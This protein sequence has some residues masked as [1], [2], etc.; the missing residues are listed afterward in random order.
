MSQGTDLVAGYRAVLGVDTARIGSTIDAVATRFVREWLIQKPELRDVMENWD[1]E[2]DLSITPSNNLKV[3]DDS[4]IRSGIIRKRISFTNINPS[5]TFRIDVYAHSIS[6]KHS[7][8]I[9]EGSC[10]AISQLQAVEKVATPNIVRNVLN[11]LDVVDGDTRLTGAPTRVNVGAVDD[12]LDAIFDENRLCTVFV[13]ASP[14][15]TED[16]NW[17]KVVEGM[18]RN[19]VG[20]SAVYVVLGMAVATLNDRL[21]THLQVRPGQVRSFA[22]DVQVEDPADG[23]RHRFIGPMAIS[24]AIN[25]TATGAL[26]VSNSIAVNQ[27]RLPRLRML[28]APVPSE[29]KRT[30]E[31]LDRIDLENKAKARA[32]SRLQA[33]KPR[34]STRPWV[35]SQE[36]RTFGG[37]LAPQIKSVLSA[38]SMLFQKWVG[39]DRLVQES[40]NDLDTFIS[41]QQTHAAIHEE[42]ATEHEK[43]LM[44]VK[45][46]LD[47]EK[48]LREH[49]EIELAQL[50]EEA[51]DLLRQQ[52]YF[53][54]LALSSTRLNEGWVEPDEH[55]EDGPSD[56]L[57]LVGRLSTSESEWAHVNEYV[58]FTGDTKSI[59][60][61]VRR[62]PL[63]RYASALWPVVRSL[64]D[65]AKLSLAGEVSC[66]FRDY[67]LDTKTDGFR[68]SAKRCVLTESESVRSNRAMK[69]ARTFPV[70]T[71]VDT[72]GVVFMEAHY[73][74]ETKDS[75]SP[76]MY[77]HHSTKTGKFYIGYIGKHLPNTKTN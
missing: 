74:I 25:S 33:F 21:P 9:V 22:R 3:I 50:Q 64:R 32:V 61:L 15:N 41:D 12:V 29:L 40:I 75:I 26:R 31:L 46:Q 27:A 62:D 10:D 24:Q 48:N 76:R 1:G 34:A 4:D 67:L 68:V 69:K 45:S 39:T 16:D 49:F 52:E 13:A 73:K 17:A 11:E 53:R 77:F 8:L 71:D 19:A 18:T 60:E 36:G 14:G 2:H 54:R 6:G 55:W 57:E 20:V 58:V 56:L 65:Y 47:A 38:L 35:E 5:G 70:P 7:T 42:L 59:E 23:L 51:D 43:A 44:V 66:N 72:D 63:G 30:V 37:T 28:E